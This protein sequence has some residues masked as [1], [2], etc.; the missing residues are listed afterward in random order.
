[1]KPGID[2]TGVFVVGICHDGKGNVLYMRRSSQARDEQNKWNIGA[3][4]TLE[5]GETL[6]QCMRREVREEAGVDV[7]DVEYIGHRE[8]LREKDGHGVHWLGFYYKVL[9]NPSEVTIMED[10]CDGILWQSFHDYPTPIISKHEELYE[11][12]K[13][14]F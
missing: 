1:M 13:H 5:H 11:L 10:A 8:I 7:T 2:Y 6:E 3:G 14:H 4:G 12:F 9:V